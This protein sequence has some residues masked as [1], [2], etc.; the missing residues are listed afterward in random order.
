MF[1]FTGC[2]LVD[3]GEVFMGVLVEAVGVGE[4][5]LICDVDFTLVGCGSRIEMRNS[6]W[7]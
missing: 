3:F 2:F 5:D 1:A 6:G 4:G 7:Y